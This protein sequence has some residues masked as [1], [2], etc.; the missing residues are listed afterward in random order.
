MECTDKEF[1]QRIYN[2]MI[3]SLDLDNYPVEESKIVEN[4]FTEGKLCDK[5][6]SE[7][8]EAN[9]RLCKKLGVEEDEDIETIIENFDRIAEHLCMRMYEYGCK[10]SDMKTNKT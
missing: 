3:D 4:E 1:K 2:L 10:F 7:I 8:F 5:A 6:Y 9:R